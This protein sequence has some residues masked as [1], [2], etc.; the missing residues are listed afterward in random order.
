MGAYGYDSTSKTAWAVINHN[1]IFS[2]DTIIQD[3]T[4]FSTSET[5]PTFDL[6][7]FY[8]DPQN[9]QDVPEPSVWALFILAVL[10]LAFLKARKRSH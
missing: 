6:S 9:L 4:G 7:A 3:M 5:T 1:S 10:V 2:S 8:V